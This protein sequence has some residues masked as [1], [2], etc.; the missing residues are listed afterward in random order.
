ML[1][2]FRD[3]AMK[4]NVIDLAVG[5]IIGAAFSKIITSLVNDVI[6]PFIG[7]LLG[8]IDLS[9]L[10]FTVGSATVQ[11]GMFMQSV[12]DFVIVAF[13]IFLAIQQ[14]QRFKKKDAQSAT[15]SV[16]AEVSLLTEIRDLLTK[17]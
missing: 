1:K 11:Y 8:K 5:V 12:L 13:C 2:E 3:F 9:S 16:S 17:K 6:M 15:P 14:L 10:S 4:G 7:L